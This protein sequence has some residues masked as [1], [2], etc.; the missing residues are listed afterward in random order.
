[1]VWCEDESIRTALCRLLP[2]A[3]TAGRGVGSAK[4]LI[5][6]SEQGRWTSAASVPLNYTLSGF[7][8]KFQPL[9][10]QQAML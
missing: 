1:M 5:P 3:H 9:G 7:E 4:Q 8:D 6:V 2:Q 10:W